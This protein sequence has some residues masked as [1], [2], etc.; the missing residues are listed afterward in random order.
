LLQDRS[1]VQSALFYIY[2]ILLL[3]TFLVLHAVFRLRF[4]RLTVHAIAASVFLQVLLSPL[5]TVP[6]WHRQT[7]FFTNEN[8][9]GYFAL[10]ATTVFFLGTRH[11]RLPS[12]YQGSFYAAAT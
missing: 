12:F 6:S 3:L 9:L 7:L 11:F 10:L 2:D 5:A 1:F 8:Q 4:L